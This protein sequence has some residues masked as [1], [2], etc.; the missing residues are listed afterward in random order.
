V[1]IRT[2]FIKRKKMNKLLIILAVSLSILSAQSF[3]MDFEYTETYSAPEGEIHAFHGT[4]RNISDN[5]LML[6]FDRTDNNIP[7]GWYSSMCIG[8]ICLSPT[9]DY[10]VLS[11]LG[12]SA[13]PP[14]GTILFDMDITPNSQGIG[15]VTVL[16]SNTDNPSDSI[17]ETWTL[18]TWTASI[19]NKLEI[20][21]YQLIGSYP[22]PFNPKTV[23]SY[24]LMVNSKVDLSIYSINGQLIENLVDGRDGLGYY[25]VVWDAS[26]YPSGFYFAR[27]TVGS[28]IQTHKMLL[29]K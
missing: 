26:N 20:L 19:D 14:G 29:I 7:N 24:E 1:R 2:P 9:T 4:I 6:A 16:V 3:T 21:N 15:I 8:G 10:V 12:Q 25:E 23:I 11:D 13:I 18:S 27:L 5:D 17:E 22:N 28:N